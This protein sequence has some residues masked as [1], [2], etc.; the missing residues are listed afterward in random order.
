MLKKKAQLRIGLL[1]ALLAIV[2]VVITVSETVAVESILNLDEKWSGD[3]NGMAERNTIRALVPYSKTF[4]F[5]DGADQRGLTYELLNQFEKYINE[6]LKR[7]TI[8][9]HVVVIPTKRDRLLPDLLEGRG[10][11][12]AGNLTITQ[13]RLKQV[14][15]AAPLLTGVDEILVSGPGSSQ[16]TT[17]DDLAGKEIHVR[18]SSSYYASLQQLNV[19]FKKAGKK[20]MKLILA[21]ELFEDEDLLEMMN[22]GLIPKIVIDSHKGTFWMQIFPKLTLHP[23][24]KLR[25]GGRIAWA[26]RKKSPQLTEVI[27]EFV[28]SHKKGTLTG[29][30]LFKRYLQNT[31]W[32]RNSLNEKE[33]QRFQQALD[34]FKKYSAQFDFD[35]LMVAALAYQESGIDQSKRSPAGAI[36]VMQMLP[37]TAADRNVN[38]PNI[39]EMENN[40]HAGVKYLRFIRN[41]YFEKEPMDDLNKMLFSFASYNAGAAKI[42]KLRKEAQDS[43]LDL[44][45]WFRNVEIIAAKRIGRETVNY[46]S[47]IYKY[48]T[49]YR[50]IINKLEMK[51]EVKKKAS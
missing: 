19:E 31:K 15:F 40:I 51:E 44:N 22:A 24:I 9:M 13:Q 8:R 29:N 27:N 5:L 41:R 50:L 3:F 34:F 16:I 43:G 37:S 45:V 4:Y 30:I 36:G 21:D 7:K 23:E 47:N 11:I 38:I 39:E 48:Y 42:A 26:M 49:A 17:I 25:T 33:I 46:V 2:S 12:A 35:W 18:A 10:D 6:K 14:D 20:Q 32:V 1:G 28:K